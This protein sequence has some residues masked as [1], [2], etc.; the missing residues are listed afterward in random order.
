MNAEPA[1]LGCRHAG[2]SCRR[3]GPIYTAAVEA[4]APAALEDFAVATGERYPAIVKVWRPNGRIGGTPHLQR[5]HKTTD[6]PDQQPT[7]QVRADLVMVVAVG[8][9]RPGQEPGI[10]FGPET[11]T[12][13]N[14]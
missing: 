4:A 11:P 13:A 14:A 9:Q 2:P 1:D 12:V 5:S 3:A 8:G 6:A 7:P 10:A